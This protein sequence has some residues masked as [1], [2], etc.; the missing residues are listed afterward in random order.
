MLVGI[1]ILIWKQNFRLTVQLQAISYYM[2]NGKAWKLRIHWYIGQ[3]MLMIM[4]IHMIA[5]LQ[6]SV[7]W[8]EI[9]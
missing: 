8:L 9:L 3:K 5:Q 7:V 1:Q 2:L 4:A 6:E